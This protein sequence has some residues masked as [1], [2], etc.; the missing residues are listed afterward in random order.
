MLYCR[1]FCFTVGGIPLEKDVNELLKK[2]EA[3]LE[4]S[5]I[6]DAAL[7]DQY[8][9]KPLQDLVD[10]GVFS[11][12]RLQEL[13]AEDR[14]LVLVYF[15]ET[16]LIQYVSFAI[17]KT[18]KV[19]LTDDEMYAISQKYETVKFDLSDVKVIKTNESSSQFY[20]NVIFKIPYRD[21]KY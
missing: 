19:M 8:L 3:Y 1:A 7:T 18:D 16:G 13:A 21:L 10:A 17:Y 4:V 6:V 2:G 5:H 12:K 11:K 9:I 20:V 15:D 14:T